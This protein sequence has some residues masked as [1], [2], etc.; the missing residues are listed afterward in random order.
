[1]HAA[2]HLLKGLGAKA[3][4]LQLPSWAKSTFPLPCFPATS[5]PGADQCQSID[6][7]LLLISPE[8]FSSLETEVQRSLY[9]SPSC[10]I[11]EE[12]HI[13]G[14]I[15]AGKLNFQPV[16]VLFSGMVL[17]WKKNRKEEH[18]FCSVETAPPPSPL[19]ALAKPLPANHRG[20]RFE[21]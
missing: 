7:S 12:N 9:M 5:G 20:K 1:M 2:E 19:L 3:W 13:V 10:G 21:R 6:F 11:Y 17:S 16:V 18:A 14:L 4:P 15:C 8:L